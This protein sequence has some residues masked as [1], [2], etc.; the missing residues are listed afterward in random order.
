MHALLFEVLPN[1]GHEPR[2][3][4]HVNRLKPALE[5]HDGLVWLDRFRSLS[6]PK[7]LLSHQ[8]W[9]DEKVIAGWRQDKQ[10]KAVQQAGREVHFEDYRIRV[11]AL[12]MRIEAQTRTRFEPEVP[13]NKRAVMVVSGDAAF[14][15]QLSDPFQSI[16]REG[17][18]VEIQGADDDLTLE[19]RLDEFAFMPGFSDGFVAVTLR[20][21]SMHNRAEVPVDAA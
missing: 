2:Y 13:G 16:N 5:K 11:A 14:K 3:F 4:D 18:F 15:Q 19:K 9:R 8:L 20:D 12:V 17:M 10:H 7:K 21:Y 1:P 6:N